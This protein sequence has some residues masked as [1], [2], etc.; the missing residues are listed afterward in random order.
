MK[1]FLLFYGNDYYPE[2]GAND[3]LGSFDLIQG[4]VDYVVRIDSKRKKNDYDLF[5]G[6]WAHVYDT[7]EQKI[8]WESYI[9]LKTLKVG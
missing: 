8:V 3:I 4:A 7:T 1:R 6:T 2:G 9:Y 5:E